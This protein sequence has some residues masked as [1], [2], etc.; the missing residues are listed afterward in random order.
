MRH[1][2]RGWTKTIFGRAVTLPT[3]RCEY[4]CPRVHWS[5]VDRL[6]G[7]QLRQATPDLSNPA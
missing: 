5:S 7:I 3:R 6:T 1:Q 4:F 2:A